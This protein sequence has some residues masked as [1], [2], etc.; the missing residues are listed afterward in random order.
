MPAISPAGLMIYDGQ[1]FPEWRGN[2][3]LGGLSAEALIRV[4]FDGDSAREAE[5]YE[6]GAR[7]REVE[8]GPA[9]AIWLLED[10]RDKDHGRLLKLEP[11]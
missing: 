8:Q 3:F 6:M 2:A 10:G 1:L 11:K 9:G 4:E 7:I 5:R